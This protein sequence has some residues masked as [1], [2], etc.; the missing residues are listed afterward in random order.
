MIRRLWA[1]PRKPQVAQ[2]GH[3][4]KVYVEEYTAVSGPEVRRANICLARRDAPRRERNNAWRRLQ[5]IE[6]YLRELKGEA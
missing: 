4:H 6:G 2:R 1:W 3:R 5:H